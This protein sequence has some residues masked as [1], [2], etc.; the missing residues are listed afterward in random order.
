MKIIKQLSDNVVVFSGDNLILTETG[1][2]GYSWEA[3]MF[4]TANAVLED[5]TD[6][7]AG[8]I[9]NCW[10]YADGIW[11]VLPAAQFKVDRVLELIRLSTV[12]KEVTP[13]QIRMGLTAMGLR[14]S[15]ESAISSGSRDLKDF[16][17]YSN[18]FER[19]RPQV[20]EMA[21][22]LG[23]SSVDLDNLWIYSATL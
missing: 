11:Q 17:F 1:T 14:S 18:T 10:T 7:P 5:A 20:H 16:Y 22:L 23:V 6:L 8:Y 2:R 21:T 9:N 15:V 12:P 13:R 3:R 4:T 19:D